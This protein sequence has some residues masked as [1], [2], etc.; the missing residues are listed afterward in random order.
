MPGF[1]LCSQLNTV[2]NFCQKDCYGNVDCQQE[3]KQ[4]TCTSF[5]GDSEATQG[6]SGTNYSEVCTEETA[7]QTYD[8]IHQI[9]ITKNAV[10]CTQVQKTFR[11]FC[12]AD[13]LMNKQV[14]REEDIIPHRLQDVDDYMYPL[15]LT[16][17]QLMLMLDASLGAPYF[18]DRKGDGSLKVV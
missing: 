15:F 3:C 4:N 6:A 11:A 12:H 9:F 10:L 5:S 2:N 13:T 16:S 7:G 14:A 17:R 8:H 18:F 1:T